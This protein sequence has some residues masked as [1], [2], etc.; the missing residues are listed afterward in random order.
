[1]KVEIIAENEVRIMVRDEM[2]KRLEAMISR[3]VDRFLEKGYIKK[4]NETGRLPDDSPVSMLN[5]SVR[6]ATILQNHGIVNIGEL[7]SKTK[8]EMLKWRGMGTG[9]VRE[10][11]VALMA[12]GLKLL[13]DVLI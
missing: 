5:L 7:C 4:C 13:D 2:E 9:S 12:Y 11:D 3:I 8:K 10:I 6:P 1:M